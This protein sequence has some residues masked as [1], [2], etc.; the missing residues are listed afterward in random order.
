MGYRAHLCHLPGLGQVGH[1]PKGN[2]WEF[3]DP[4]QGPNVVRPQSSYQLSDQPTAWQVDI[5]SHGWLAGQLQLAS[6]LAD[7]LSIKMSTW[8]SP[9]QRHLMAKFDTTLARMTIGQM[10]LLPSRQKHLVAKCVTTLVRLTSGHRYPPPTD[11]ALGQVEIWSG[12]WSCWPSVRCTPQRHLVAKWDTTS[13]YS[14]EKPHFVF[15]CW[16]N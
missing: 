14:S 8:P 1:S 11:Q 4:G 7:C 12:F 6:W 3:W 13:G 2:Q 10:Y 15:I 16:D 9:R 5:L